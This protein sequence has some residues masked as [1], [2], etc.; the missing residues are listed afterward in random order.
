MNN[1]QQNRMLLA[2][3]VLLKLVDTPVPVDIKLQSMSDQPVSPTG[4]PQFDFLKGVVGK[5]IFGITGSAAVILPLLPA[6][7]ILAKVLAV[8]VGLGGAAGILSPGAR[9]PNS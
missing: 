6:Q 3:N 7:T 4:A 2:R 9:T 1:D 8:V 5:I